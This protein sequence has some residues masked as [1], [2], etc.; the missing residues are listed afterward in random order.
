MNNSLIHAVTGATPLS[1]KQ[2]LNCAL[3]ILKDHSLLS[4]LE[5]RLQKIA[6]THM[7]HKEDVEPL[8]GVQ[9]TLELFYSKNNDGDSLHIYVC[10]LGMVDSSNDKKYEDEFSVLIG[11]SN[12]S[13]ANLF[14]GE[15]LKSNHIV[16]D[17]ATLRAVLPVKEISPSRFRK[18]NSGHW[19]KISF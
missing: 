14:A 5:D 6:P 1:D 7:S 11:A 13:E 16:P 17:S 12:P 9:D 8:I 10:T 15:F 19:H 3:D 4:V 18:D 2:I